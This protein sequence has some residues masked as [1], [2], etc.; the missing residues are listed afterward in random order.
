VSGNLFGMSTIPQ[1]CDTAETTLRSYTEFC[2]LRFC[3][4]VA[5]QVVCVGVWQ[6][7]WGEHHSAAS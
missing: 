7:V 1:P 3:C 4:A 6:P 5:K 2:F